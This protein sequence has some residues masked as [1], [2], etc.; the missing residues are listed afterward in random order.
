M[1]HTDIKIPGGH[2]PFSFVVKDKPDALKVIKQG[3]IVGG[4]FLLQD[5]KAA[6]FDIG[7]FGVGIVYGVEFSNAQDIIKSLKVGA[8]ITAKVVDVENED[9]Y[10]ELSLTEATKHK[11]WG[12]IQELQE[13]GDIVPIMITGANSGG[14]IGDLHGLKAFL[15]V[16]QLSPS[17]YPAVDDGDKEKIVEELKKFVGTE[18]QVKVMDFNPRN[19]KLILSERESVSE[20]VKEALATYAVGDVVPGIISGL[21]DFGAFMKFADRP[22]IEGLIH[23]SELDHRLIEHPKDVV[24][25]GDAVQAKIIDIKDGKVTLSLKALKVDPWDTLETKYTVGQE[26]TGTVLRFNPFGAFISIGDVQGLIHVSEFGSVEDM[27][28]ALVVG[29]SYTFKIDILKPK[30]KRVILKLVK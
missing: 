24:Q 12:E 13:K 8:S 9:G 11:A 3:D 4:K 5:K 21:A 27:A 15:P 23:I 7:R 1:I 29:S 20:N 30:E 2:S 26:V 16:S 28:K 6:F 25:L 19:R 10:I 17:H 14:L 18:L 22:E